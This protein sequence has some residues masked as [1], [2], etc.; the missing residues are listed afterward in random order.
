MGEGGFIL[1]IFIHLHLSAIFGLEY[2]SESEITEYSHKRC[3]VVGV[4]GREN[5]GIE[6]NVVHL[7]VSLTRAYAAENRVTVALANNNLQQSLKRVDPLTKITVYPQ[8]KIDRVCLF[9]P[10]K[11]TSRPVFYSGPLQLN[12]VTQFVNAHCGTHRLPS[13]QLTPAALTRQSLLN[14]IFNVSGLSQRCDRIE[15]PSKSQFFSDYLA[16]SKP[17][18]ITGGVWHWTAMSR[19]TKEFLYQEFGNNKVHVK[20]APNGEFEGCEKASDWGDYDHFQIPDVVKQ[21]LHFPDLVVVRPATLDISF[22]SFL[23]MVYESERKV[24]NIST[25]L[26][27]SSIPQYMPKL[28]KDIE[29]LSFVKGLLTRRQLNLWLS[30]GNTLGKLHFDPFDNLLCQVS[31]TKHITLYEPHD[32]RRLYESHIP[33]ALL[34]F[35]Q[36]TQHFR[37]KKLLD[38][39]S[40]VMS[41]IDILNPDLR[42]FPLFMDIFPMHCTIHPGDVLY[43][44]AFWWHEV[45]S[46]P[47][48]KDKRNMAVNYWYEPFYTKEFPC[49]ECKLDVNEHYFH[50]LD[51]HP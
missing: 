5:Q 51:D 44:P 50:L 9:A 20:L 27:Y 16:K 19:W 25:Y 35:D 30:D 14:N 39:T 31:G 26:E 8:L 22:S 6:D 47:D 3:A 45:Q 33:E 23:D 46:T 24:Q 21:K 7:L 12:M 32:N 41:P 37:R 10:L 43:M 40:M 29:E 13:G 17:V 15:I 38:S 28:E 48:P 11:P 1:V 42:R 2:L 36:Q 4:A 18:V 49:A 34:G